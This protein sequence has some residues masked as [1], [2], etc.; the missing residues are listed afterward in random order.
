MIFSGLIVIRFAKLLEK[1]IG[2]FITFG[3]FL[4]SLLILFLEL[5]VFLH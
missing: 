2:F 3:L 4:S 1:Y 5:P